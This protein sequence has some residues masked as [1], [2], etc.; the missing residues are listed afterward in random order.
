MPWQFL[1]VDGADAQSVFPLPEHGT[2]LIGHS[3]REVD[4]FLNDLYVG[5]VHCE[6]KVTG[7]GTVVAKHLYGASGSF[8]NKVKIDKQELKEG[9]ILR[10]GNSHLRLDPAATAGPR[11]KSA[12]VQAAGAS[13]K[14]P[15][16]GST[17]G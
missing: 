1:V 7:E 14:A 5:R 15:A 10:V 13:A 11:P 9:D 4:I 6:V 12:Q 16:T 17:H 3:H 2:I 8:V